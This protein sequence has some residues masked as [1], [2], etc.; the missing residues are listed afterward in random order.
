RSPC[1]VVH[2]TRMLEGRILVEGR[3]A[4]P[5]DIENLFMY[6][7]DLP[8]NHRIVHT[9]DREAT[10]RRPD[11][12]TIYVDRENIFLNAFCGRGHRKQAPSK[13]AGAQAELSKRQRMEPEAMDESATASP[14]HISTP[15]TAGPAPG[16]DRAPRA[17]Q[18]ADPIGVGIAVDVDAAPE[19]LRAGLQ[20]IVQ[21]HNVPYFAAARTAPHAWEV[22]FEQTGEVAS[23]TYHVSSSSG[24]GGGGGAARIVVRY[25]RTIDAF[26]AL[27]QVLTAARAAEHSVLN[28]G[29]ERALRA[30]EFTI[31]ETAQFETLALMIDCSRNGV[32]SVKS[33][34]AMLRNMALMGYTMLQLYTEDTFKVAGEPFFGYLRGGYTQDELRVVDD[35]AFNMGIEVVPCIQTL[36]HL[37]QMLQW[38]RYAGLRDTNE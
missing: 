5:L 36:G 31:A 22:G 30:P 38:P 15:I 32:L 20:Q 29:D 2:W 14:M 23:G 6:E 24:G 35:Y 21:S 10:D 37:G 16:P 25:S 12:L 1:N 33:I 4:K 27:G 9:Y 18:D 28:G 8:P 17:L 13:E 3:D 34:W 11:R 26:R 19:Q 7:H